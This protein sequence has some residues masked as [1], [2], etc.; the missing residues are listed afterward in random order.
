MF[1]N[2]KGK[3]KKMRKKKTYS[4]HTSTQH[5][6]TLFGIAKRTSSTK[7]FVAFLAFLFLPLLTQFLQSGQ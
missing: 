5:R 4:Y 3:K 1:E 6:Q 2:K 7:A